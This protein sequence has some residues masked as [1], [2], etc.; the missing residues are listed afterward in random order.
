MTKALNTPTAAASQSKKREL[1]SPEF[2][3][4]LNKNKVNLQP[5]EPTTS[6]KANAEVLVSNMDIKNTQNTEQNNDTT[7]VSL[8]HE[9]IES[10]ASLWMASFEPQLN[11]MILESF[12]QQ[13]T[14]LVNSIVRGVLQGFNTKIAAS[15]RKI[16]IL[17]KRILT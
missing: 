6:D 17:R 7:S 11:Q 13:V 10:I 8:N 4:E 3:I 5:T 9:H 15:K 16:K 2:D 12:Q 1:S 14:T